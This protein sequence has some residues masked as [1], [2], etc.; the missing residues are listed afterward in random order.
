MG[1]TPVILH[2]K[3]ALHI[4]CASRYSIAICSGK[5]ISTDKATSYYERQSKF[6]EHVKYGT[7]FAVIK[8]RA[9]WFTLQS[10]FE[11]IC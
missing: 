11:E 9:Y 7:G 2:K 1:R 8:R 10:N 3:G 4:N 6:F 5:N